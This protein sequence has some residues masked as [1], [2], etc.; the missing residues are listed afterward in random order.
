[1]NKKI[2]IDSLV[3][4]DI[5]IRDELEKSKKEKVILFAD[6]ANSTFIKVEKNLTEA[7]IKILQHNEVVKEISEKFGGEVVKYLGDAV[8]VTFKGTDTE[9]AIKVAVKIL[10]RFE[11]INKKLNL[12]N[13]D[14]FETNI[15]ISSGDVFLTSP[16]SN[17]PI[18][19]P[20]DIAYRL[21]DIGKPCQ[22]LCSEEIKDRLTKNKNGLE[23]KF[24]SMAKREL[25]GVKEEVK[26]YEVIWKKELG[27]NETRHISILDSKTQKHLSKGYELQLKERYSEAIS[28]YKHVLEKDPLNFN[29]NLR[30]GEIHYFPHNMTKQFPLK[31]VK[32][33]FESAEKS[34]PFSG[35]VKNRLCGLTW[36]ISQNENKILSDNDFN[37]LIE[38][39]KKALDLTRRDIDDLEE[40]VAMNN[41]AYFYIEQYMNKGEN[42]RKNY[43]TIWNEAAKL[44]LLILKRAQWME[45]NRLPDYL[46]SIAYVLTNKENLKD[47]DIIYAI[48]LYEAAQ[49]L[50][51][52]CKYYPAH[53]TRLLDKIE[54]RKID[55]EKIKAKLKITS[56]HQ[57]LIAI[58]KHLENCTS[59]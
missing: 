31:R 47:D 16:K 42:E 2:N 1:M 24:S 14:K 13:I 35:R 26:I 23:L 9:K 55:Q 15:G 32:E 11:K 30:L 57:I 25:K 56:L 58:Q 6:L 33:F 7:L 59:N 50:K 29:A 54:N 40:V 28:E 19:L 45:E 48:I 41:L 12:K 20:V 53:M 3:K 22:I 49:K 38:K 52:L 10:K 44:C 37:Y 21:S 18:G 39:S 36:R 46:D 17:D 4:S 51:P 27:I 43:S 34:N 8:L 5:K